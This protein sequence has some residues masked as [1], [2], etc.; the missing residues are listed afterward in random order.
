MRVGSFFFVLSALNSL[1]SRSL[2][3]IASLGQSFK[4]NVFGFEQR[5]PN[6]ALCE[7]ACDHQNDVVALPVCIGHTC[8]H[9]TAAMVTGR[10][11][12]M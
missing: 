3:I 2:I 10:A 4:S 12:R 6:A 1:E 7:T 9:G 8:E 5:P 11:D